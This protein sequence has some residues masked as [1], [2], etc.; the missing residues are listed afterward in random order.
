MAET[1][2]K[3]E[4]TLPKK[5]E[6]YIWFGASAVIAVIG[7]IVH[8]AGVEFSTVPSIIYSALLMFTI[9]MCAQKVSILR[10]SFTGENPNKKMYFLVSVIYYIIIF[11]SIFYAF[12]ALWISGILSV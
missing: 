12:L 10:F 7:T 5:Q 2:K 3:K 4:V 1:K 8:L 6:K 9:I 11:I